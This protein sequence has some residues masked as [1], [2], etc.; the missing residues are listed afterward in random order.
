[1]GQAAWAGTGAVG[2]LALW[3]RRSASCQSVRKR[4][5]KRAIS[6]AGTRAQSA[7]SSFSWIWM[8]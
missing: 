7:G 2:A 6:T 8:S 3:E 1:M 4:R 5:V